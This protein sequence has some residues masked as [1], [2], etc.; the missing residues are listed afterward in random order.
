MP[1]EY[2]NIDGTESD[3]FIYVEHWSGRSN[4]GFICSKQYEMVD[5]QL[6]AVG[7]KCLG[8]Q[9]Y[10]KELEEMDE[11]DRES[12]SV[13]RRVLHV[14]NAIHL[15]HYHKVPA[16]DR[17]EKPVMIDEYVNNE[18]TGKKVQATDMVECD[19][20]RC[21]MCRDKLPRVFGKKVHWSMGKRHLEQLSD[22]WNEIEKDC[23]SCGGSGT[24]EAVSLECADCGHEILDL[25]N[26]DVTND[27]IKR[28]L[29]RKYQ[30]DCGAKD[31]P[32]EQFECADCQDP[33]A[34]SIFDVDLEVKK[35]GE[36]TDTA[37]SVV[38]WHHC[39]LDEDLLKAVGKP[40]KFAEIFSGDPMGIQAQKLRVKNPEGKSRSRDYEEKGKEGDPDYKD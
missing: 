3:F 22:A 24:I 32:L 13:N 36:R 30:C 34:T 19:G 39:E 33:K 5:G 35:V 40:Y 21:A 26:P 1:G 9:E 16:F 29:E 10:T 4:G 17:D 28:A 2:T 7:G 14:F 12:L 38:R 25:S 23:A 6:N 37:I 8:C 11:G 15:A 18:K 20:R 31:Y 27:Q